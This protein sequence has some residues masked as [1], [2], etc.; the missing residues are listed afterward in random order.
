MTFDR[1]MGYPR[2]ALFE[3]GWPAPNFG[4]LQEEFGS[5]VKLVQCGKPYIVLAEI[6]DVEAFCALFK[7]DCP[8]KTICDHKDRKPWQEQGHKGIDEA[9]FSCHVC[10]YGT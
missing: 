7:L 8:S 10:G 6:L 3:P 4:M 5:E 1:N 9:E 2:L